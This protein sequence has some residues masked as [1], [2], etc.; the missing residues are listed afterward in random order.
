MS[1][2]YNIEHLDYTEVVSHLRISAKDFE[3][4]TTENMQSYANKLSSNALFATCKTNENNLI[5]LIAFYANRCPNAY[6]SHVW[7]SEY[8]R[9]GGICGKL[10]RIIEEYCKKYKF[11]NL[12]LE[13][14][15]G[16]LAAI[17]AYKKQNFEII[18]INGHKHLME[19]III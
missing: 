16:N 3:P 8:H 4:V 2:I 5:G 19:K 12:R 6:I 18:S 17:R 14:I 9:G 11:N 13:V 15:Q 1:L 7:V 10:L